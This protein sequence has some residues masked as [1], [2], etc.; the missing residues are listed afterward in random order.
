[1]RNKTEVIE[2]C[3]YSLV[4]VCILFSFFSIF[5][6]FFKKKIK[7]NTGYH[8]KTKKLEFSPILSY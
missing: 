4:S 7:S 5:H 1:M 3:F 6:F 2:N 8:K